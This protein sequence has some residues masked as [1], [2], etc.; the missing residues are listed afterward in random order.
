MT[1]PP[2]N[3]KRDRTQNF[4]ADTYVHFTTISVKPAANAVRVFARTFVCYL[5]NTGDFYLYF[6]FIS[7]VSAGS[8]PPESFGRV[9]VLN[10]IVGKQIKRS[11]TNDSGMEFWFWLLN[12]R[13]RG[14]DCVVTNTGAY[15]QQFNLR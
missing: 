12:V 8:V 2:E 10:L 14:F 7:C 1:V 3:V 9:T 15:F 4:P 13:M 5:L 6:F 11:A